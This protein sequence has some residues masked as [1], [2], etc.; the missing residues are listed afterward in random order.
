MITDKKT[1]MELLI[2]RKNLLMARDPVANANI[3]KKIDRRLRRMMV[4][5]FNSVG[6]TK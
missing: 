3:A 6:T 2:A 5:T 4:E 1:Q